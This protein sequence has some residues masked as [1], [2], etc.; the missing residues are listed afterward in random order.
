MG[1]SPL[2]DKSFLN[3]DNKV[4]PA[5][6]TLLMKSVLCIFIAGGGFGNSLLFNMK[7]MIRESVPERHKIFD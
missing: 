1:I 3:M 4:F 7:E 5:Y 2:F 6:N